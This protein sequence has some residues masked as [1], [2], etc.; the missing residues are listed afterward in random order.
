MSFPN[1]STGWCQTTR[2]ICAEIEVDKKHIK[3]N[4]KAALMP[5][6]ENKSHLET[7]DETLKRDQANS[8]RP[9]AFSHVVRIVATS[10]CAPHRYIPDRIPRLSSP[11]E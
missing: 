4:I 2:G 6:S 5:D 10:I 7:I 8:H 9:K 1:P 3:L 11:Q